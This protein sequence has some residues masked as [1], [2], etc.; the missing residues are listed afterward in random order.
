MWRDVLPDQCASGAGRGSPELWSPKRGRLVKTEQAGN[1]KLT[2]LI[3]KVSYLASSNVLASA[4]VLSPVGGS[5][6]EVQGNLSPD[7]LE[8]AMDDMEKAR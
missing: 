1:F 7:L 6:A 3:L 5:V 4:D 2:R 8:Q